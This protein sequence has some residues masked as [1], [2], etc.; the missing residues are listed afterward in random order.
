MQRLN[1]YAIAL[2]F[3]AALAACGNESATESSGHKVDVETNVPAVTFKPGNDVPVAGKPHGPLTVEYRIIG[4]PVVGQPVAIDLKVR[5]SLGD[6]PVDVSYRI[7]DVTAM[8]LADAQPH[9]V[10]MAAST[11]TQDNSERVTIVP[12]REGRLFLNVSLAVPSANG[13]MSTVTAI[14]VQVGEARRP[15]EENGTATTDENGEAIRS[16]PAAED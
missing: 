5:S 11:D 12:L 3:A 7:N 16:L 13:S 14:P 1:L 6:E 8:K 9:K 10:T 15:A 2:I 4:K